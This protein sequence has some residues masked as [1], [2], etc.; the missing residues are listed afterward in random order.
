MRITNEWLIANRTKAG[1]YTKRQ[2]A[3]LGVEWPPRTG[4]KRA[5]IGREINDE[6]RLEIERIVGESYRRAQA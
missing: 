1:G 4:W 3:L 2:L 5:V 6:R